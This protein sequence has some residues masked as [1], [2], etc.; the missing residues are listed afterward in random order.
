MEKE[1]AKVMIILQEQTKELMEITKK[2]NTQ[3]GYFGNLITMVNEDRNRR[4][5]D[6]PHCKL[7]ILFYFYLL[8]Y[9]IKSIGRDGVL[10][11][12]VN[13]IWKSSK[14]QASAVVG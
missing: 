2:I 8:T 1:N 3:S 6:D 4:L 9:K 7:F 5:I 12:K 13:W 14:C 10:S 11:F